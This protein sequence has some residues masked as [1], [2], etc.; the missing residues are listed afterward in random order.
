M[1]PLFPIDNVCPVYRKACLGTFR[2]HVIH[3]KELSDFKYKHDFV[4]DS[5]FDIPLK[6]CTYVQ[7]VP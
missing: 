2:E 7:N 1:I 3:C 5:L 4:R 6:F